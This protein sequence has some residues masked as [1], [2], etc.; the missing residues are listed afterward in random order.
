MK[1]AFTVHVWR[2]GDWWI[3]QCQEFE[4]A[5]QG[6]TAEEAAENLREALALYFEPL[7]RRELSLVRERGEEI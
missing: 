4:I 7:P 1:Q 5:S 3:A 6:E 2:D